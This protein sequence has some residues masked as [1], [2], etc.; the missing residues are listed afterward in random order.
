M[1]MSA[2]KLSALLLVL[3]CAVCIQ[4]VRLMA[5]TRVLVLGDSLSEGQGVDKAE[6]F[7]YLVAQKLKAQGYSNVKV[8][9]AGISGS[10]SASAL[11]RLKWHLRTPPDILL[12]AL[13][14][15]DGLRG[16]PI[17]QMKKNL[18]MTIELALRNGIRVVLAGM[19]MPPN[20]GA[21]YTLNYE[22][23]F[24]QLAKKYDIVFIPFLLEGVGGDPAMNL[25]DGIHPNKRGHQIISER[26]CK[27]L[28]RIL[29]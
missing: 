13:G 8:I 21:A 3:L 25:S 10:T 22:K 5:E 12:L 7:P 19:K 18:A 6:A 4:P 16:L 28:T 26:V 20:Y 14:A 2:K 9:N 1:K 24:Q 17:K 15:N 23:A 27:Y 11:S 29:Q